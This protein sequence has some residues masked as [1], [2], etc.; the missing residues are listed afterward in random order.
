MSVLASFGSVLHS[1]GQC[2][3]F[4]CTFWSPVQGT[5]DTHEI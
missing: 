2:S 4:Q 3:A 1:D 5:S